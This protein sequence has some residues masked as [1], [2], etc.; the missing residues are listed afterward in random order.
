MWACCVVYNSLLFVF[1]NY[2]NF[3]ILVTHMQPLL[4]L[5]RFCAH[6][7][8]HLVIFLFW[9]CGSRRTRSQQLLRSLKLKL[10]SLLEETTL[11]GLK[12][13]HNK[14]TY[15]MKN[16]HSYTIGLLQMFHYFSFRPFLIKVTT[17]FTHDTQ[18]LKLLA[19]ELKCLHFKMSLL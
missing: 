6:S 5:A 7:L 18:R 10:S 19:P 15:R 13:K 8:C 16:T 1:G 11:K 3:K 14:L 2:P 4:Y 9:K 17:V 12:G